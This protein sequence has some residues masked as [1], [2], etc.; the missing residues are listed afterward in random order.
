M[1]KLSTSKN[2]LKRINTGLSES[3]NNRQPR[4]SGGESGRLSLHIPNSYPRATSPRSAGAS[5]NVTP[6]STRPSS[7]PAR[8]SVFGAL[9]GAQE[10]RPGL[11]D[12]EDGPSQGSARSRSGSA[13]NTPRV[14]VF[15]R[16]SSLITIHQLDDESSPQQHSSADLSSQVT[17]VHPRQG[18]LVAT[19]IVSP[20]QSLFAFF[21]TRQT[22]SSSARDFLARER[23]FFI[24]LRLSCLLAILSASLI[25]QLQFPDSPRHA[26]SPDSPHESP[27]RR[28]SHHPRKRQ[29]NSPVDW[30]DLPAS[31]KAFAALFF[32]LSLLSLATGLADYLS[33]ERQLELEEVDF[34]E[35]EGVFLNDG[36][37]SGMVH[38]VMLCVGAGVVASALWLIAY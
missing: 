13:S 6:D 23:N 24:W 5:Q 25:L 26:S 29:S 21:G 31:S 22:S 35:T 18:S 9:K 10:Q 28:H 36:H 12:S 19:H 16:D 17:E 3:S 4:S 20:L 37:T 1:P 38:G 11:S 2:G 27:H 7:P 32:M 34:D 15:R 33:A 8:E 30:D 14:R